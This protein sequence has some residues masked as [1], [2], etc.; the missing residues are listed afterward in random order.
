[1]KNW[2]KPSSRGLAL[3]LVLVM[4]LGM[5]QIPAFAQEDSHAHNEDGW[6][7][8][9]EFTKELACEKHVHDDS[10]YTTE[11]GELTCGS[12][13]H[14]HDDSCYSAETV[15]ECASEK[16]SHDDGCYDE[17][18]ELACA[19]GEHSHGSGCYA[20]ETVLDC[21]YEEH[22]HGDNCREV[23]TEL[24]CPE[25]SHSHD[26][27]CYAVTWGEWSCT[28]PVTNEFDEVELLAEAAAETEPP[29]A[30]EA[31]VCET[32]CG[33]TPNSKCDVCSAEGAAIGEVCVGR[34]P[35]PEDECVCETKCGE[36]P[37]SECKVCSAEGA[38]VD[39]VCAGKEPSEVMTVETEES[40]KAAVAEG[41]EV[42]L[43]ADITLNSTLEINA[44]VTLDLNGRTLQGKKNGSVVKVS[45]EGTVFTLKDAAA[46]I[47]VSGEYISG[48]ITGGKA[49][50]GG[51][52]FVD[53]G[54]SFVMTSGTII[55]NATNGNSPGEAKS[56]RYGGGVYVG[57]NA[58]FS[59]SGGAIVKNQAGVWASHAFGCGVY[60]DTGSEFVLSGTAS[61][62]GN[63]CSV[64]D[65]RYANGGGVCVGGGATFTMIGGTVTANS[66]FA[67]NWAHG[68]GVCVEED[69]VFDMSGGSISE[70]KGAAGV[71]AA[72]TMTMS[73][74]AVISENVG[75]GVAV[76]GGAFKMNGGSI[77]ANAGSG[78]ISPGGSITLNKGTITKND[79]GNSRGG[80]IFVCDPV[81]IYV[82]EGVEISYNKAEYGG[83]IALGDGCTLWDDSFDPN[84]NY[85]LTRPNEMYITMVGGKIIGNEATEYGGGVY[86]E[87]CDAGSYD[88]ESCFWAGGVL[89]MSGGE[90]SGNKAK[91]GG[92]VCVASQAALLMTGGK[93]I[94][95]T[96]TESGGGVYNGILGKQDV[97]ATFLSGGKV[98]ITGGAE[99]HN[100]QAINGI[101]DD[102][103]NNSDRDS[104]YLI[105]T[106]SAATRGWSLRGVSCDNEKGDLITGWYYDGLKDGQPTAR[107]NG[108][109]VGG[110]CSDTYVPSEQMLT[111]IA[112]KAAHGSSPVPAD[113]ALSW[114][115]HYDANGGSDA[116]ADQ[117]ANNST[118][119]ALV[120][121]GG[122]P[123]RSGHTF[124]GW[125]T[126]SNGEV[127][128]RAGDEIVLD[129]D[130]EVTTLYAQWTPNSGGASGGSGGGTR[131]TPPSSEDDPTPP[132]EPDTPNVD[133][134][135]PD[136]PLSELP[137]EPEEPTVDIED[138]DIPLAELPSLPG[139]P[140]D[141]EIADQDVPLTGVPRTGDDSWIWTALA[142]TSGAGLVWLALTDRKR[143]A[144]ER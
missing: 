143:K 33:E 68:S 26:D 132:N 95:N 90:I 39:D 69:G 58:R 114:I 62:S 74:N 98:E 141:L 135:D 65:W 34:E 55:Q 129:T 1:M 91:N 73:E 67:Y 75:P 125:S 51:G 77:C 144:C 27:S 118:G 60:L 11:Q 32:K 113:P 43:G 86:V 8:T 99:L 116:P 79:A 78:I 123:I 126:R 20:E 127:E 108:H 9:Q 19:L 40:L 124:R 83:G 130:K 18:G 121:A 107:W 7:C 106:V 85:P 92:G 41:G 122:V 64:A 15:Q 57:E 53:T 117:T 102:I 46:K 138:P 16:H 88:G 111:Q 131:P 82:G 25:E 61:I 14:S 29:V 128:Y 94:N 44:T 4:C 134:D 81:P 56:F 101:G 72:G 120:V 30:E 50:K 6:T 10:C 47:D 54:A 97:H 104:S 24:T 71:W 142:L 45:G 48:K 89:D 119:V 59:M 12:D 112:L 105:L 109:V 84:G 137:E 136:V 49:D 22:S 140:E 133:I 103:C 110:Y 35:E 5:L 115:L 17:E 100:N 36:T 42:K 93:I 70:N 52:V 37:N 2:K 23:V 139:E 63:S 21:V 76:W 31:C 28:A 13:E 87:P 96:A 3:F 66:I 38:V 80:G